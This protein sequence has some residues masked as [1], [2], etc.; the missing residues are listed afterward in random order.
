M[1][2]EV[3]REKIEMFMRRN[4]ELFALI[5]LHLKMAERVEGYSENIVLRGLFEQVETRMLAEFSG[6]A[7]DSGLQFLERLRFASEGRS[8]GKC[9]SH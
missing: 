8:G 9:C 1:S 2:S 7:L 6:E 5:N 3:E 4:F